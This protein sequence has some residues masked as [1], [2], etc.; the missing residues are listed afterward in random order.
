MLVHKTIHQ[1]EKHTCVS[2]LHF[3]LISTTPYVDIEG[4]HHRHHHASALAS[5]TNL[6]A[7]R[8]PS[9]TIS[10]Q[11]PPHP[12][13]GH[14]CRHLPHRVE[15]IPQ[16][17]PASTPSTPLSCPASVSFPH[18]RPLPS[19]CPR[20]SPSPSPTRWHIL[21]PRLTPPALETPPGRC[22]LWPSPCPTPP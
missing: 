12:R 6:A 14:V 3:S 11:C 5:P 20:I 7:A 17:S 16:P 10:H 22:L 9:S 4:V 21:R 15:A 2:D 13:R 1:V 8:H 18:S 19:P